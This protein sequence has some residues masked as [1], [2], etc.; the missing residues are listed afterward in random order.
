MNTKDILQGLI[1]NWLHYVL[2]RRI[3]HATH[4]VNYI[5]GKEPGHSWETLL[6][7][8][9]KKHETKTSLNMFVNI[10]F[11]LFCI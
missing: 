6:P 7:A 8:I 3:V 4:F 5:G 11:I 2:V 9:T 1:M 10:Y